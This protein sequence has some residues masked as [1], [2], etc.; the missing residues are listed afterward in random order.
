[1]VTWAQLQGCPA[2]PRLPCVPD[3]A[4]P[5]SVGFC[6]LFRQEAMKLPRST[7]EE[8]DRWVQLRQV[9]CRRTSRSLERTSFPISLPSEH[10]F[11]VKE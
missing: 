8:R 6:A 7:P 9:W 2:L 5:H 11:V 1:M 4:V 3:T 10:V